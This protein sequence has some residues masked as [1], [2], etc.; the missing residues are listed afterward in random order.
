MCDTAE[1]R[2]KPTLESLKE[3]LNAGMFFEVKK[4][5]VDGYSGKRSVFDP[6]WIVWNGGVQTTV[7]LFSA[8][9]IFA[10]AL[11]VGFSKNRGLV[12]QIPFERQE[13]PEWR[14]RI[15]TLARLLTQLDY[16]N[17]LNAAKEVPAGI[18]DQIGKELGEK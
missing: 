13:E 16:W 4:V 5:E 9:G 6:N 1:K 8:S 17:G 18:I 2:I 12:F 10:E 15:E 3:A 7:E 11:L 14:R